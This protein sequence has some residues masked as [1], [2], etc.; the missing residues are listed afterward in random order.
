[1]PGSLLLTVACQLQYLHILEKINI[2]YLT[3]L[4]YCVI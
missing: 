3:Y 2:D 1:M 4:E